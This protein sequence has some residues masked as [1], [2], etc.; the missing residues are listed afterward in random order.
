M[1]NHQDIEIEDRH[2]DEVATIQGLAKDNSL[3]TVRVIPHESQ[4]ANP[5]FDVTPARLV[6]GIITE[7]GVFAPN[8]LRNIK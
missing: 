3:Q 5:A 1:S 8:A 6:T 7:K 4:T 2:G